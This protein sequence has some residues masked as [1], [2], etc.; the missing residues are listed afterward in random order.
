MF[1]ISVYLI[2][3]VALTVRHLGANYLADVWNYVDLFVAVLLVTSFGMFLA[4]VSQDD[5][6]RR[7]VVNLNNPSSPSKYIC[8]DQS[9]EL[10]EDWR[11]INATLM[12]V[13]ILIVSLIVVVLNAVF[14]N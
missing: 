9:A 4:V 5:V 14:L 11:A 3:E 13:L 6:T 1:I 10:Q 8:F 7:A 12:F 2:V